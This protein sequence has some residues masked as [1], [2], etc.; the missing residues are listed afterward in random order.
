MAVTDILK[1]DP[2]FGWKEIIA[3][4]TAVFVLVAGVITLLSYVLSK[5]SSS[6][7]VEVQLVYGGSDS[8]GLKGG[9]GRLVYYWTVD[10]TNHGGRTGALQGLQRGSLPRYAVGMRDMT[11]LEQPI[12]SSIYVFEKPQF[13]AMMN[14]PNLLAGL[15]PRTHEELLTLN[16]T[17][18]A[19]ETRSLSFAL[20]VDNPG[21]PLEGYLLSL[22]LV[23]NRGYEYDL[24]TYVLFE[25]GA[26]KI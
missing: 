6:S 20:A 2:S 13:D 4:A 14:D 11:L 21:P 17:L 25:K 3:L 12:H 15:Q 1:F 10:M 8:Q 24:S 7:R 26:S 23:F 9:V 22:K 18:P 5:R 19:G 16:V